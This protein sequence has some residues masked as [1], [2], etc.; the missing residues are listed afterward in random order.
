M[1]STKHFFHIFFTECEESAVSAAGG[2]IQRSQCRSTG[3]MVSHCLPWYPA[4]QGGALWTGSSP[5]LG[6]LAEGP[7]ESGE[8]LTSRRSTAWAIDGHRNTEKWNIM[9]Y[10]H[11]LTHHSLSQDGCTGNSLVSVRIFMCRLHSSKCLL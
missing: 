8:G 5:A 6:V 7:R 4:A 2:H 1:L 10:S 3:T 9:E 11:T